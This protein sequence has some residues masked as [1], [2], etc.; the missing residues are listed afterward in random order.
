MI[1]WRDPDPLGSPG[2]AGIGYNDAVNGGD[3]SATYGVVRWVWIRDS[4][5]GLEEDPPE[6]PACAPLR[7]M[8]GD[9]TVVSDDFGDGALFDCRPVCW[10][11]HRRYRTQGD[12]SVPAGG[13]AMYQFFSGSP[14]GSLGFMWPSTGYRGDVRV[15]T[16]AGLTP[17]VQAAIGFF[18][19]WYPTIERS[20]DRLI[21]RIVRADGAQVV[22]AEAEIDGTADTFA[23]LADLAA[24][25][26]TIDFWVWPAGGTRSCEPTV[27]VTRAGI[28]D[29]A[30]SNSA[31]LLGAQLE[32]PGDDRRASFYGTKITGTY[33]RMFYRGDAN[34]DGGR[35]L[36]DAVFVL[37]WLFQGGVSPVCE[38]AADSNDDGQ[39]DLSDAVFV[40]NYLFLGGRAPPT[41]SNPCVPV[42]MSNAADPT[43]DGLSCA[44]YPCFGLE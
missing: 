1:S 3:G 15:E 44:S 18:S 22:E 38:K 26:G 8:E 6:G 25:E 4:I 10:R 20:G 23:L 40:L 41:P 29:A 42:P 11:T 14:I 24:A 34:A 36:S 35:D 16:I 17:G 12:W 37:D 43:R 13:E 28:A 39:I 33:E 5:I 9:V 27:S 31:L 2:S 30:R 32:S 19:N 7:E 21:C